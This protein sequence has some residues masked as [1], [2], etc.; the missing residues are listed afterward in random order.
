MI[1][2][3][4]L[5]IAGSDSGG[6]A[7][8]QADIKAIAANGGYAVTAITSVTAQNT[9]GVFRADDLPPDA[10][11]AQL[12]AIFADFSVVAA[13]TGMLPSAEVVVCV[14]E[15]FRRVSCPPLVVD[16]VIIAKS[17]YRLSRD[18]AVEAMKRLLF[19]LATVVTPNAEEAAILTGRRVITLDDA[20]DVALALVD[21]GCRAVVVKG[22]HLSLETA[23]DLLYDGAMFHLF[24]GERISTRHTHGTGCTFSAALATLLGRGFSLS[25]AVAE[26]KAYVLEAIRHGLPLGRGNGPTNHF[27]K[28]FSS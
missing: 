12:D 27:W 18:D 11:K 4:I 17:G 26:A 14:A 9:L 7:G 6:G 2:P 8:I 13:K 10:V 3:T 21:A 20:R 24:P 28:W 1:P 5:T 19:P 22:G 16:P 23:T 25:D 15:V